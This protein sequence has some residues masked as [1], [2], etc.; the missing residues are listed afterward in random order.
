MH[1]CAQYIHIHTHTHSSDV[2]SL[3]GQRIVT[4][5]PN[6]TRKYF[7]GMG[8]GRTPKIKVCGSVCACVCEV[9]DGMGVGRPPQIKLTP[10]N[11]RAHTHTHTHTL[12]QLIHPPTHTHAHTQVISGSV[13][14]S[15]GL[16][17]ADGIVDL[18]ETGTTM[19]THSRTHS[20]MQAL[21]HS[22]AHHSHMHTLTRS[23]L[24]HAPTQRAAGL[25]EVATIMETQTVM[26]ANPKTSHPEYVPCDQPTKQNPTI[27]PS[28]ART[29]HAQFAT[30]S[31]TYDSM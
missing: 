14:A 2:K 27:P 19:V 7:D 24:T 8:V 30:T 21:T 3:S 20:H 26:I 10:T 4:S 5:F 17:L 1:A 9:V 11:A 18:V 29:L 22:L 6:V 16:G 13:E 28:T 23:S 15:C 25:E 31:K 12:S